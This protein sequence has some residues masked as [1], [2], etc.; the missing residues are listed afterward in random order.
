MAK[1]I[2]SVHVTLFLNACKRLAM[3]VLSM[4]DFSCRSLLFKPA[5]YKCFA[6]VCIRTANCQ[7]CLHVGT[8]AGMRNIP[9][10]PTQSAPLMGTKG[11]N[12]FFRSQQR[13]LEKCR[14][15]WANR[16]N[17]CRI[18]DHL[19][20]FFRITSLHKAI[21][22]SE[23]IFIGPGIKDNMFSHFVFPSHKPILTSGFY[24]PNVKRQIAGA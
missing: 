13:L 14:L 20:H 9:F 19:R 6:T 23:V 18:S 5:K 24:R 10:R 21:L 16:P 3:S 12:G 17:R 22:A 8:H 11:M 2:R 1:Y 15:P 7:P 4:C